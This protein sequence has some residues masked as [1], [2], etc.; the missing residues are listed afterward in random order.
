MD[1]VSFSPLGDSA[2]M[3]DFGEGISLE[4]NEQ[5][6]KWQKSII[7]KPFPGFIESVPAYTTLTIFFDPII[8]GS[9][10]PYETIKDTIINIIS[11]SHVQLDDVGRLVEIPVCYEEPFALDLSLVAEHNNIT[12][13]EVIDLH[14]GNI[15]HVFFLGFAPGFP[16]LGGMNTKI[17]TPRKSS[18]RLHVPRGSVGI[19]GGQTGIYPL[20]SPGGWQIIGR[21]PLRLFDPTSNLPTLLL[22][23]NN[24]RFTPISKEEYDA[25]EGQ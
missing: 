19:A 13:Q 10:S 4:K 7:S 18:P 17:S 14:C 6:L 3:I 9:Y 20:D 23:G 25:L 15:Y 24:I 16:F 22:P 11:S 2:I 12:E 21:T 5:I 8:V 1:K